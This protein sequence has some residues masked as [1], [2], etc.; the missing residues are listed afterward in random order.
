MAETG[1]TADQFDE[2]TMALYEY[3]DDL[4]DELR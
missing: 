4:F 1:I 2:I 3:G